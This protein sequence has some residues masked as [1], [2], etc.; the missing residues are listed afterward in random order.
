MEIGVE[1]LRIGKN[2]LDKTCLSLLPFD[3]RERQIAIRSNWFK[4]RDFIQNE[5]EAR[6]IIYH[7]KFGY[8]G[9]EFHSRFGNEIEKLF[10]DC[11]EK[12]EE[13]E[14]EIIS[15]NCPENFI[16]LIQYV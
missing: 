2:I 10:Q 13:F 9:K 4:V 11:I 6:L 8:S 3:P 5:R 16:N 12:S 1:L 15:R 7:N 14:P